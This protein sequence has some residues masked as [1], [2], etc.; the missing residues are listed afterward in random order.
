M[1]E[2]LMLLGNA[3]PQN[4]PTGM[5]VTMGLLLAIFYFMLWRPQQRR[6]KERRKTIESLRVGQRVLFAGGFVGTIR[7]V[8]NHTFK[9]EIANGVVVEVARGAISK[10]LEADEA[11]TVDE[12]RN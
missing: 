6:D 8:N 2:S 11:P 12:S 4:N 9:I 1:F 7:E 5:F 10:L 3:P